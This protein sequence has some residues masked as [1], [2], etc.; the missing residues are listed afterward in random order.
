[1]RFTTL[2]TDDAMFVCLLNDVTIGF[3]SNLTWITGGFELALTITLKLQVN[4]LT[5]CAS[6]H[7]S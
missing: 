7:F 5:K 2:L 4:R 3:L 1:M 6:K